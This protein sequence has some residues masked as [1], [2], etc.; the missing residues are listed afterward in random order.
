MANQSK[1][2]EPYMLEF[3]E[4]D[5]PT[6]KLMTI[7]MFRNA[8]LKEL[9]VLPKESKYRPISEAA[10]TDEFLDRVVHH[11]VHNELLKHPGISL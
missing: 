6:F 4:R 7:N 9:E 2:K 5:S 1:K 10:V 11:G 3:E 8:S